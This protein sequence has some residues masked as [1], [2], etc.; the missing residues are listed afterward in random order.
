MTTDHP[1]SLAAAFT[2][3]HRHFTR[4]LSRLLKALESDDLATAV[5]LAEELDHA[6]GPHIEFEEEVFY[7]EVARAMGHEYVRELYLEH[8]VGQSALRAL[9]SRRDAA[10]SPGERDELIARLRTAMDH[11]LS[12]GTLLSH[13]TGQG[14]EAQRRM[15]ERRDE[16]IARGRRWTELPARRT[17]PG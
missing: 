1:A 11:A 8:Q 4:G 13:V 10:L 12:C 17:N 6:V 3:D 5:E 7:P 15:L 14:P 16:M 9:L 2:A